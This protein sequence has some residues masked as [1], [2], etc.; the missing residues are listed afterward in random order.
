MKALKPL[1]REIILSTG[2]VIVERRIDHDACEANPKDGGEMTGPEWTE[3]S[4]I[5]VER[6]KHHE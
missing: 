6:A 1:K 2:R 3:Y 5:I 4:D